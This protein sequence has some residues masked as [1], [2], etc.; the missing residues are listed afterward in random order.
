MIKG[1]QHTVGV[2]EVLAPEA[3]MS[4]RICRKDLLEEEITAIGNRGFPE[5]LSHPLS[6]DFVLAFT[7]FKQACT[8]TVKAVKRRIL[9]RRMRER[10]A[11]GF[12][13]F[14]KARGAGSGSGKEEEEGE[15]PVAPGEFHEQEDSED[16][17]ACKA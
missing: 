16:P 1:D 12:L 17:P 13:N 4:V 10:C 14:G 2:D 8:G 15:H 9:K 6:R 11:D 3:G 7:D 5:S